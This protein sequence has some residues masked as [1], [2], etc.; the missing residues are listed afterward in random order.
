MKNALIFGVTGQDGSYLVDFLLKKGYNVFGTF[1]RTS[2]R[3]FERV[4]ELGIFD[5]FEK[6]KADLVD[7]TSI[8]AAIRQAE[9]DEVYN[10]AAQSFV[11]ASFQQPILTSDVN[12][13]GTIRILD[14]LRENAPEAKFYQA[15]S[16]EM[17]GDFPGIK[18]EQTVFRPRSPYGAAK[19]FAHQITNHYKEAYDIFACCG[20]LFNHESPL[21]GL[22][23]V[24]RKIT[25]ELALI[26]Y[27][28]HKKFSLGNIHAKRDWGFA[29]D[30]VEAMWL[31]LQQKDPDDYVIATGESHSV[32][33]FL[34]LAT[35]LM[36]LGKW[37]DI[38]NIDESLMR[39]TDIE[40]LIG[41]ASKAKKELG[42]KPK[43]NFKDLVKSMVEHDSEE[44]KASLR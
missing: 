44:V 39:P 43:T 38:V 40:D 21:R 16:S 26:K 28:K 7:Q 29:G 8:N 35:E 25:H 33:E 5:N 1:R 19:V 42:W 6:I 14:S 24:T 20:I 2:H 18:N 3:C 13:I 12:G 30:Y 34:T 11:G 37:E 17:F 9:P 15:S 31:M 10:L 36:E 27:K 32:K 23:F 22:E 4:E 41:D